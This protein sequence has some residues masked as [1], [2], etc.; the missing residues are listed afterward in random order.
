MKISVSKEKYD[1]YT[2][3]DWFKYVELETFDTF[4]DDYIEF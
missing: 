4:D 3:A 2:S 1:Q